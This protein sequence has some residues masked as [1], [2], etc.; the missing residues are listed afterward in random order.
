M[1]IFAPN[2]TAYR[3][4]VAS[5]PVLVWVHGGAF[6]LGSSS[7]LDASTMASEGELVIVTV[8]YRLGALGFFSIGEYGLDGNYALLDVIEALRWVQN[9]IKG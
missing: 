3:N 8:N 9:N 2:T 1:N 7:T 6:F 4:N 5:Y